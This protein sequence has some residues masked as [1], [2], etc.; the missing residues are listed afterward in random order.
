MAETLRIPE[1]IKNNEQAPE[2]E[3]FTPKGVDRHRFAKAVGGKPQIARHDRSAVIETT[4]GHFGIGII[5]AGNDRAEKIGF[6]RKYRPRGNTDFMFHAGAFHPK[7]ISVDL[8]QL[9]SMPVH[10]A[11]L[12]WMTYSSNGV[13]ANP[14][15]F[16]YQAAYPEAPEHIRAAAILAVYEFNAAKPLEPKKTARKSLL[17][18][19]RRRANK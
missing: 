2:Y 15:R 17:K 1:R 18:V 19:L 7:G 14:T 5:F 11:K 12:T 16:I 6:D 10:E 3:L 4:D 9:P 13:E 8:V